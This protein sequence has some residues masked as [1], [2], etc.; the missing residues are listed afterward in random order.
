MDAARKGTRLHAIQG[1]TLAGMM[2]L[3]ACGG[4]STGS[5]GGSKPVEAP[6]PPPASPVTVTLQGA[7]ADINVGETLPVTAQVL[8]SAT[9]AV[10]W[11]VD[12]IQNGNG[13]VG[14]ITGSGNT[15]TYVAPATEGNHVVAATSIAEPSKSARGQVGI[16]RSKVSSITVGPTSWTLDTGTQKQ[17]T[18]TVTGTGNYDATLTWSAKL[19]TISSTGLYTAPAASGT[20]VVTATSVQDPT[21]TAAASVTVASV[22]TI[23]AVSVSPA[24]LTLN[25]GVQKQFTAA[26]AG[27]GTY[28]SAVT[29]SSQRGSITSTG[30]YTAPSTGGADVVTAMSA[31]DG[32]KAGTA[33]ITVTASA[34]TP[35]GTSVKTYGAKGDGLTDDTLAIQNTIRAIASG[36][37]VLVP[38][39]TY[40]I[41]AS[42]DNDA[43]IILKSNMTL[44]LDAGAVLKC[45]TNSGTQGD[46]VRVRGVSNVTISGSG[47]VQG[48]RATHT[49][50][51]SEGFM[52]ISINTASNI[53]VSGVTCRDSWSDGIYVSDDCSNITV[54]S[55]VCD[56]NRRQGMSITSVKG[57]LVQNSTFSNTHGTNPQCGI[58]IEPNAGQACYDVHV[59]GCTFFGNVGGGFQQGASDADYTYTFTTGTILEN[60]EF[61][62]NGGAGY[63]DGG[64]A[65]SD[66]DNNIIRNNNIHNNLDGGIKIYQHATNVTV[67]GNTVV[68]NTGWGV[69]LSSCSGSVVTGNTVTGNSGTGFSLDSSPGTYTPNTV[70][71]NG[72]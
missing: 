58:D 21:K 56:N 42:R 2:V 28:N 4:S 72:K 47:T 70:N 71:G 63:H 37:T 11:T 53:T 66:C 16:H 31:Q 55:V 14:T 24:S 49:G 38:A 20:D 52:C 27:T 12:G 3:S 13:D 46:V 69:S 44:F 41:N 50:P 57:M 68:N 22:S 1:M 5:S 51:A 34:S 29:W 60:C 32:T 7:P 35:A 36:G 25:V 10:S 48:D 15:V 30:L 17:F 6:P 18:A 59:T 19:G 54:S 23:S 67:T 39:G 26:V 8:G 9:T 33:S 65:F 45:I 64:I 61:Y 43:G 62:G 40:M